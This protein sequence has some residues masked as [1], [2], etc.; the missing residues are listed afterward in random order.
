[1]ELKIQIRA[2][3]KSIG[4]IIR[5]AERW[6]GDGSCREQEREQVC[7]Q[8]ESTR[9]GRPCATAKPHPEN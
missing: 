5:V 9:F 4:E 2:R 3:E 6:D 8:P 1:M 7:W